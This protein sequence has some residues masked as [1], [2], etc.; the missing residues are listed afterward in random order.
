MDATVAAYLADSFQKIRQIKAGDKGEV[1]LAHDETGQPVIIKKILMTG[2]PYPELKQREPAIYPHI[3]QCV[4][5]GAETIVVEEFLPGESLA[6]RLHRRHYLTE[7]E[8]ASLLLQLCDGLKPLHERGIIHRD[9]TPSNLILQHGGILRLI[10][11]DAARTVKRDSRADTH[12]LGTKGYAPP[13]QFGY[14]QTD[15][16]SDIYAMGA[17]IKKLLGEDYRGGLTPILEKCTEIDPRQR[18]AS[19][20]ALKQAILWRQQRQKIKFLVGVLIVIGISIALKLWGEPPAEVPT[21]Q[22][23]ATAASETP[24]VTAASPQSSTPPANPEQTAAPQQSEPIVTPEPEAIPT[25][26]PI[27]PESATEVPTAP[28]PVITS[29]APVTEGNIEATLYFNGAVF[30]DS[31]TAYHIAREAWNSQEILLHIANHSNTLW[32]ESTLEIN[33]SDNWGQ[34]QTQVQRLPSIPPGEA[35][36]FRIPTTAFSPSEQEN[37][38]LWVQLHLSE[39][40]VP[41][42]EK[43]WCIMLDLQP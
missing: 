24:G 7:K 33:F 17:T 22:V 31:A 4:E 32:E 5:D 1:W 10:D 18:Y 19:V 41:L 37:T 26:P 38:S 30:E 34:T 11:F 27:A 13:E 15:A 35:T 9:I 25:A 2:L 39:D 12:L 42:S 23:I 40:A 20:A 21:T 29:V 14:G 8:A 16:R 28:E 6:E 43:Y 3:Y 36:D